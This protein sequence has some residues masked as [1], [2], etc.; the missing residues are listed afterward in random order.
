MQFEVITARPVP[1]ESLSK[2]RRSFGVGRWLTSNRFILGMALV[3]SIGIP[4]YIHTKIL[5]GQP[6]VGGGPFGIEASVYAVLFA[7][8]AGHMSIRKIGVLPLV[9]T[10]AIILPTFFAAFSIAALILFSLHVQFGRFHLWTG[11][12][13]TLAWYLTLT[14]VRSRHQRPVIGLFGLSKGDVSKF[15]GLIDWKIIDSP[16]LLGKVAAVV[17]DPHADFTVANAKFITQLVLDG[18]PV[19]HRNHFEESLTGKVRFESHADNNFGALLPSLSYL[20]AKRALDFFAALLLLPIVVVIIGIAAIAIKV[21]S[22]GPVIFTQTRIGYRGLPFPCYKLRTMRVGANGPAFTTENDSRITPLGKLL[23]KWRID[24]LPQIFNILA[25]EMSW[26]GPRPEAATLATYYSSA[27]PFYDYRHAVRPGI[28]G[29]AA[30]HQGN[31]AEVDAAHEKLDYDFY[32]IKYFSLW[33]DFLIVLKTVKTVLTGF[34]S[35]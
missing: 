35:R 6:V 4:E 17:V 2:D 23:R 15:S 26:I 5:A 9:S 8:I 34:G 3:L 19:Y 20:R 11:L 18:T 33:L 16:R 28:T 27:I 21:T 14:V 12:V 30:V 1:A 29:W 32:Y 24:E 7:V 22:P 10:R 13:I 31:V 25:G